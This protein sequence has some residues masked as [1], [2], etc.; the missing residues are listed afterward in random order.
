MSF[1]TKIKKTTEIIVASYTAS[2]HASL[3]FYHDV[4]K[5]T[6][7]FAPTYTEDPEE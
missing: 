4:L 1:V 3:A 7:N 6:I 2:V 5:Q